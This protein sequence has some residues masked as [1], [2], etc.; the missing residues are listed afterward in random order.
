MQTRKEGVDESLIRS[1]EE[2][3]QIVEKASQVAETMVDAENPP[4]PG[5]EVPTQEVA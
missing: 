1:A 5:G 4:T 3:Q 2:K